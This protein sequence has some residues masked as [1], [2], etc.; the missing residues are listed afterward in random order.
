MFVSVKR[1]HLPGVLGLAVVLGN[2]SQ[3]C[4]GNNVCYGEIMI[5]EKDQLMKSHRLHV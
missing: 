1:T 2:V 4:I 5:M 3:R